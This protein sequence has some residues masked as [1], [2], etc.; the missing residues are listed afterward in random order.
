RVCPN[1]AGDNPALVDLVRVTRYDID[2]RK[3]NFGPAAGR[4]R[5][6]YG[7]IPDGTTPSNLSYSPAGPSAIFLYPRNG[8]IHCEGSVRVRGTVAPGKQV[9]VVS[10]GSIYIEG[11][12]LRG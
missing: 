12:L 1:A 4:T 6:F 10:N 5:I 11:N 7:P 9:T 3:M 8:V 2:S